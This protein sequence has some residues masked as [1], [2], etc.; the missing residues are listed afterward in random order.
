M[1]DDAWLNELK[2]GDEVAIA[3]SGMSGREYRL[4]KV[5]RL[6][7]T[8]IILDDDSRYNRATGWTKSGSSSWSRTW[9]V[10][11]TPEVANKVEYETLRWKALSKLEDINKLI[12][13]RKLTLEQMR[14]YNN[15]IMAII[16]PDTEEKTQVI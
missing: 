10:P 5:A 14:Q 6:T 11:V 7:K 9:I 16:L 13:H 3:G 2:V 1:R 8:V 15:T 12:F 4:R